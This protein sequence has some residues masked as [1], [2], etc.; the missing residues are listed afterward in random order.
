M[1]NQDDVASRL[2]RVSF[3]EMSNLAQDYGATIG[4]SWIDI[5]NQPDVE[6]FLLDHKWPLSQYVLECKKAIDPTIM[7]CMPPNWVCYYFAR[8][9]K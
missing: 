5:V 8:H 7:Q 6:Q 4:L 9:T 3:S 1:Y 2:T